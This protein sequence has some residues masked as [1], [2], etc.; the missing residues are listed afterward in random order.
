MMPKALLLLLL[1]Q[2]IVSSGFSQDIVTSI[3]EEIFALKISELY[4]Q[5][6]T[7]YR[8]NPKGERIGITLDTA[9][10]DKNKRLVLF[11]IN[12]KYKNLDSVEV[13]IRDKYYFLSNNTNKIVTQYIIPGDSKI[14]TS[15]F[16]DYKIV[17]ANHALE[18]IEV[19]AQLFFLQEYSAKFSL[20]TNK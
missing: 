13:E 19:D 15:Y 11:S 20:Q 2:I 10:F 3:D 4:A 5:P 1:F 18:K 12:T 17:A 16:K 9:F 8:H 7:G 14:H 6:D